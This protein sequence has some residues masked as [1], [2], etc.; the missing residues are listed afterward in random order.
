VEDVR[1]GAEGRLKTVEHDFAILPIDMQLLFGHR[2]QGFALAEICLVQQGFKAEEGTRVGE[3]D[4]SAGL[5]QGQFCQAGVLAM[6]DLDG[7]L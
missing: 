2:P 3:Q 1:V 4:I 5:Q 6:I 7:C